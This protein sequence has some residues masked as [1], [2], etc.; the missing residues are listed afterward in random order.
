MTTNETITVQFVVE[1]ETKGAWRYKEVDETGADA[2]AWA[3]IG[4]LYVRKTAFE[5]GKHTAKLSVTITPM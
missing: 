5:K 1:K 4:T 2:G 3:K